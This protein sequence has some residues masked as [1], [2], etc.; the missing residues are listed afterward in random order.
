[1]LKAKHRNRAKF[2]Y[3]H[4]PWMF[5]K[6][7]NS[8]FNLKNILFFAKIYN[9][10]FLCVQWEGH[11]TFCETGASRMNANKVL[12][13]LI[14]CSVHCI[15]RPKK[16]IRKRLYDCTT[17]LSQNLQKKSISRHIVHQQTF[18]IVQ[19]KKATIISII[20]LRFKLNTFK[21]NWNEKYKNFWKN[22]YNLIFRLLACVYLYFFIRQKRAINMWSKFYS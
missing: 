18:K 1:M 22:S 21:S 20:N 15:L 5:F 19:T 17:S 12:K 2:I 8:F 9:R 10:L 16:G 4:Q 7:H 6:A 3:F 14:M 11:K 13:L